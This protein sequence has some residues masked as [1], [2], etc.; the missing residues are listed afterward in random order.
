MEMQAMIKLGDKVRDTIT[1]LA[2]IAIARHEY[3]NGCV[4]FSVQP[5]EIKDGKP[6]DCSA[7]DVEQLELIE[8]DYKPQLAPTGGPQDEPPRPSIPVR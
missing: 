3:L 2:G 8:A 5:V 6:V 7:F 4:R 1:G